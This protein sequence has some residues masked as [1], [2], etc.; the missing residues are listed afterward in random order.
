MLKRDDTDGTE[1]T[2]CRGDTVEWK[3]RASTKSKSVIFDKGGGSPFEWSDSEFQGD[4]TT[5]LVASQHQPVA[6]FDAPD[7]GKV[8]EIAVTKLVFARGVQYDLDGAAR[9]TVTSLERLSGVTNPRST[10]RPAKVSEL[11]AR[12]ISFSMDRRGGK[13]GCEGL[14][15]VDRK[16]NTAWIVQTVFGKA[17]PLLAFATLN[18]EGERAAAASNLDSVSI[19]AE[20]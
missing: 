2:V 7:D 9:G 12:R 3:I 8:H 13:V 4:K 10:I 18:I 5:G 20:Q 15:I 17:K 6:V 1:V 11:D 19:V 16:A 14:D